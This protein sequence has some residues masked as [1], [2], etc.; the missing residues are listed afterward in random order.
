MN[1]QNSLER[2][3]SGANLFILFRCHRSK[4]F[5]KKTYLVAQ[6]SFKSYLECC[7]W[8]NLRKKLLIEEAGSVGA[9]C[10]VFVFCSCPITIF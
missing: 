9:A 2:R 4:L 6:T 8:R 10:S 3:Q 1:R 5:A 7:E